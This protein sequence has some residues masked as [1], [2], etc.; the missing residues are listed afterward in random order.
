[1]KDK[2]NYVWMI[3]E[4]Y[5]YDDQGWYSTRDVFFTRD[6][7]RAAKDDLDKDSRVG[8][9]EHRVRKYVRQDD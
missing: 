8:G 6:D 3:E 7:A 4:R 1:M 2:N 5:V 9:F